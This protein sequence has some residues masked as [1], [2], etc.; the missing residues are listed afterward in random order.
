MLDLYHVGD[1]TLKREKGS[2]S[3]SNVYAAVHNI[4][5]KPVAIKSITKNAE[6][7]ALEHFHNE[8]D[9]LKKLDHPY[10]LKSFESFEDGENFYHVTELVERGSLYDYVNLR[11]ALSELEAKFIFSQILSTIEYLHLQKHIVHRDLKLENILL[12]RDR[13]IRLID[14]GFSEVFDENKLFD[15]MV[16]SPAYVAPELAI[17]VPYDLTVDVWS[18]GVILYAMTVGRLPFLGSTIEIQLKRVVLIEPFYPPTLSVTL[19]DLL[20]RLLQKDPLQRIKINEIRKHPWLKSFEN[21]DQQVISL[22]NEEMVKKDENIISEIQTK[23]SFDIENDQRAKVM[24]NIL[25]LL[26]I[27]REI[28]TFIIHEKN[29]SRPVKT[30]NEN[31]NVN[32]ATAI[33]PIKHTSKKS[34]SPPA[35]SAN[36]DNS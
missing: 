2:G 35:I 9:I 31:E 5:E 25:H 18:L 32:T 10:I 19:T 30:N 3:F 11:G 8:V 1:Y 4:L 15:K 23:T 17:G 28:H 36:I 6:P 22:Y 7:D 16:G 26:N 34:Q 14:F 20:K 12:D 33:S 29:S 24:Y 21:N 13:K 27:R